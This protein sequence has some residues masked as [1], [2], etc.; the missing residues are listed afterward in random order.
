MPQISVFYGIVIAMYFDD[1]LPP[2]F[3]AFYAEYEAQFDFNGKIIAGKM[4]NKKK[5]LIEAWVII[6]KEDLEVNWKL[7]HN[8]GEPIKIEP[9]K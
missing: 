9:L 7:L 2:H 1:H 8:S 3:H 4:P 6:H 5:K